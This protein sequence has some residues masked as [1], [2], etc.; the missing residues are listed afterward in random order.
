MPNP[1]RDWVVITQKAI[2]TIN[3]HIVTKENEYVQQYKIYVTCV[4]VLNS[5]DCIAVGCQFCWGFEV[6]TLNALRIRGW[7]FSD[8][9]IFMPT[10]IQGLGIGSIA[11]N[12]IINAI[13]LSNIPKEIR[14][15]KLKLSA[16]DAFDNEN[17]KRRNQFYRN[18]GF[19]LQFSDDT[20]RSG[21]A[22]VN[23]I[24]ELKQH[25][26]SQ[27][28]DTA[29]LCKYLGQQQNKIDSLS[30]ENFYLKQQVESLTKNYT[31]LRNKV[32]K[33]YPSNWLYFILKSIIK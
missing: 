21:F 3:E 14:V 16:H 2:F 26:S 22:Y 1:I 19:T 10:P 13:S 15:K 8:N 29:S 12:F 32:E 5:P 23:S 20:E 18:F 30:T 33:F 7:N 4:A 24:C 6:D 25:K 11:M 31:K 27:T 28:Y 17:K 9:D